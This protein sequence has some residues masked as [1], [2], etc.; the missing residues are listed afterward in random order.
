[1]DNGLSIPFPY[2]L[3]MKFHHK[4]F[5]L[6]TYLFF[7]S[8]T[9]LT[10]QPVIIWDKIYGSY[11]DDNG[12]QIVANIE[13][14]CVFTAWPFEAGTGDVLGKKGGR[15]V[16]ACKLDEKGEIVYS[17]ILGGSKDDYAAS[18]ML[19]DDGGAIFQYVTLSSDF[20]IPYLI[21]GN[22]LAFHKLDP[23]GKTE[24]V[25]MFGSTGGD[26]GLALQ[27][28]DGNFLMYLYYGHNDGDLEDVVKDGV[29]ALVIEF[30]Q[31]S[32]ALWKNHIDLQI[33]VESIAT[34]IFSTSDGGFI[35][36]TH[37]PDSY[38]QS[39]FCVLKYSNENNLEWR[40]CFGGETIDNAET[41]LEI[42]NKGYLIGS[43]SGLISREEPGGSTSIWGQTDIKIYQVGYN[44]NLIS[45]KEIGGS[46]LDHIK[47]MILTDDGRSAILLCHTASDD[48]DVSFNHWGV[49]IWLVKMD[50]ATN[51]IIWEKTYG[52]STGSEAA[53]DMVQLEDGSI[54]VLGEILGDGQDGD[55]TGKTQNPFYTDIWVFKLAPDG[56]KKAE[57]CGSFTLSPNPIN[58]NLFEITFENLININSSVRVFDVRGSLVGYYPDIL[59]PNSWKAEIE[60][61]QNLPAGV[62][63]VQVAGC[64]D[65]PQTQKLLKIN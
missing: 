44:G 4:Y 20:D 29:G 38:D 14:D 32:N 24:W 22:D 28:D 13:G 56:I 48:G 49:D 62:Y 37:I 33:G 45:Q 1:M 61:P 59:L 36:C 55:V 8:T 10:G 52:S 2:N 15:D 51:G 42:P 17:R 5:L 35:F 30:D 18:V 53:V 63:F 41:I 9:V 26:S 7:Y 21:G 23:A 50:L 19:T 54:I 60:L 27:K 46:K 39:D 6:A 58:G 31:E 25:R 40:K 16:W 57:E 11:H 34:R 3:K 43:N 65:N 12:M 64:N 47:K